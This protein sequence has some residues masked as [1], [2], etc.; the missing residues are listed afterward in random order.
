M[1]TQHMLIFFLL[2][3]RLVDLISSL[4]ILL[5]SNFNHVL[6]ISLHLFA[7]FLDQSAIFS[8]V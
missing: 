2:M 7:C 3:S 8:V 1:G 4:Y 5:L 6:H